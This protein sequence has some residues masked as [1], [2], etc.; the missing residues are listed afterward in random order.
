MARWLGDGQL[1]DDAMAM[2]V[3]MATVRQWKRIGDGNG[4]GCLDNGWLGN[5]WCKGLAMDGLTTTCWRWTAFRQHDGEG[6]MQRQWA[7]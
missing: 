1:D 2:D 7:A 6:A 3:M 4:N 5:G